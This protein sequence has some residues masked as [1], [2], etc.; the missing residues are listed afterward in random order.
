M[1]VE[2][3]IV[4]LHYRS[5]WHIHTLRDLFQKEQAAEF[6]T[7]IQTWA[8]SVL[9]ACASAGSILL[10]GTGPSR[11]F[12]DCFTTGKV[13]GCTKGCI[14]CNSAPDNIN[15]TRLLHLPFSQY[16]MKLLQWHLHLHLFPSTIQW[17]FHL[18]GKITTSWDLLCYTEYSCRANGNNIHF[19]LA[20]YRSD[21]TTLIYF[22]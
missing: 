20:A 15:N 21:W 13:G 2:V 4:Y 3:V 8:T 22:Y 7:R 10:T 17:L 16:T 19:A 6:L 9:A 5:N 11:S 18:M 1:H 12:T 14:T